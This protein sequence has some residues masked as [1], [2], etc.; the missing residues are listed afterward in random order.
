MRLRPGI[1]IASWIDPRIEV[2]DSPIHGRGMFARESFGSGE[3]ALIW[4]GTVFSEAEVRAGKTRPGTL[5]LVEEGIYLGDPAGAQDGG[6]YA[7]N[8]V[9]DGN[10]WMRDALTLVTR[11]VI[12]EDEELTIDYALWE[13]DPAWVLDP[14]RCGS[15]RCRGRITGGDWRLTELQERYAGYFAPVIEG[16]IG[17]TEQGR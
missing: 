16:W 1:V 4:G 6:D 7:L 15:P 9:C 11:D 8:H 5:A 3:I 14:C 12:E 2:R 13:T 17:R 10:L